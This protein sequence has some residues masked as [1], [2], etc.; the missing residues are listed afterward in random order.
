VAGGKKK[1]K[2]GHTPG[3]LEGT[4][5]TQQGRKKAKRSACWSLLSTRGKEKEEKNTS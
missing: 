1:K 4:S 5:C 2:R 3:F